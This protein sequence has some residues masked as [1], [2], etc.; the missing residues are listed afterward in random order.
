MFHPPGG[1]PVGDIGPK[2]SIVAPGQRAV[3]LQMWYALVV[4]IEDGLVPVV[5]SGGGSRRARL[6]AI[7]SG[8][9]GCVDRSSIDYAQQLTAIA[10]VIGNGQA[11]GA[12][13]F[14]QSLL[15]AS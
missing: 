9:G 12:R 7:R 1:V 4:Q 6:V 15:L 5:P 2:G 10:Q 8:W 14:A 11:G 3:S 13:F